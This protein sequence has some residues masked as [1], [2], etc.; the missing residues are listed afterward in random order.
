LSFE[1]IPAYSGFA[2][3]ATAVTVVEISPVM[4]LAL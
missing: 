3:I 1:Y 2:Q 4:V